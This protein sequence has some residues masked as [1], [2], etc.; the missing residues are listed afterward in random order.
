MS[1]VLRPVARH[2]LE[3]L[4]RVHA[5]CFPDDAWDV[6]ALE[7]VLAMAG[8]ESLLAEDGVD[9]IGLLFATVIREEAEILGV[10]ASP[11]VLLDS[12]GLLPEQFKVDHGRGGRS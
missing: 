8:A 10:P 1:V 9:A 3:T 5:Q 6:A 7:S 12:C 11:E 4:A 2:D